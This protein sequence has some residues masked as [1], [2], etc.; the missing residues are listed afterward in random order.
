[1]GEV[2]EVFPS[3]DGKV[4]QVS[5]RYKSGARDIVVSRSV[6][7]LSVLVPVDFKRDADDELKDN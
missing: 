2:K 5:V 4:R 3:A 1:M 6:H 7:R